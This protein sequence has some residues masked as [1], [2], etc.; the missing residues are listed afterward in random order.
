MI[1]YR[2]NRS[3]AWRDIEGEAVLIEP[4]DGTVIV[5]NGVGCRVWSLL[6]EP[7]SSTDITRR[8]ADEYQQNEDDVSTDVSRFLLDLDRRGL[9][10]EVGR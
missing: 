6:E 5:L 9:V 2:Q 1:R 3:I 4:S 10:E 7:R 8:I